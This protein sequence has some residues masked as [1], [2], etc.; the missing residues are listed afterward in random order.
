MTI[1][2][3]ELLVKEFPEL[4]Q[5]VIVN[6]L[7][8]CNN[9]ADLATERLNDVRDRLT[10]KR[11]R[12]ERTMEPL[13]VVPLK[14]PKTNYKDANDTCITSHISFI[15][16]DMFIRK[17]ININAAAEEAHSQQTSNDGTLNKENTMA[18][19]WKGEPIKN[20][21]GRTYYSA[22]V[23]DGELLEIGDTVYMRTG[24]VEPWFAQI[25]SF[26]DDKDADFMF[27][28][29]FFSHGRETIL[30][31]LAGER[32]L[33][34]L[35]N[36]ADNDLYSVMGK[37]NVI[38]LNGDV[39]EPR[40]FSKKDWWFYRL[41]YD[42]ENAVFED[43]DRHEDP[44]G[45]SSCAARHAQKECEI[46]KWGDDYVSYQGT[47]Y[48]IFD[49]VYTLIGET[50]MP[51]VI[52][53]II[54]ID[55][56]RQTI[57]VCI[58]H[59]TDQSSELDHYALIDDTTT[60]PYKDAR[61]LDK[62]EEIQ[63]LSLENLEGKCWVVNKSSIQNIASY[64]KD[65]ADNFYTNDEITIC[66]TCQKER[67]NIQEQQ[68]K[69]RQSTAKLQALD[70][71]AGCGG[72][73]VGMDD[74]GIIHTTHSIE[75]NPDAAKTFKRNF[76]TSTVH[77]QC[78]N[79]LLTRAIASYGHG[80]E[81]P[82]LDDF[83][84][85]PLRAMPAPGEIDFIYCG[86]PC[87]GFSVLN[88]HK[89]PGEIKNTLVCSAMSYVDFYRPSYFLL[90]NVR[91]LVSYKLGK[92]QINNGVLKF[93][94][95]CLTSMG[96]QVRFAVLQAAQYGVAQTRRRLFVWGAKIG[97]QLPE[98]PQPTTCSD[99][100]NNTI[101]KFADGTEVD[102]VTRTGKRAPLSMLTVGDTISDLP[103]FDYESPNARSNIPIFN[104]T[105]G[106]PGKSRQNYTNDPKTDFQTWLRGDAQKLY[107]HVTR[108]FNEINVERIC[109]IK[110]E[111]NADHNTL[112]KELVPWCLNRDNPVA[113]RHKYWPG[114]YG[115]LDYEQQFQT[116]VTELNP[117]SKQGTVIHPNQHR[118]LTV[119]EAARSQ[120]FP[121]WFVFKATN[122]KTSN[123]KVQAMY[124]QIGNAVPVPLAAILGNCLK[125]AMF[126]DWIE[127]H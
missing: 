117:L 47:E 56:A 17:M 57:Q 126:E 114:L 84:G 105:S 121:D 53:Q 86:P 71:F 16:K 41:W 82:P 20:E 51:Y 68:K 59:R 49:F 45:C 62:T 102:H 21:N 2:N 50:N 61:L 116:A 27:H 118:V 28:A 3:T 96:Y 89:K 81:L 97:K 69:F 40:T 120:G 58:M 72:L 4:E 92:D 107:N 25:M 36:C 44:D 11:G 19:E 48:H 110:M 122:M 87:Q 46:P 119:R 43:A 73:T 85:K 6:V 123:Q 24:D 12:E 112:P 80:M 39:E 54:G 127:E 38:R 67:L 98:F 60:Q 22:A 52:A 91:G 30:D 100:A 88:Q 124:M 55:N 70:I 9:D 101:I 99:Y 64:K 34:L 113:K 35:D 94:I 83:H 26:F 18:V 15:A 7:N 1:N 66:E 125:D 14:K 111:P 37:A 108:A 42:P 23:V 109:G 8:D 79:V 115:R 32:E 90:E 63:E 29:R 103:A 10:V 13:D 104:A 95:R 31:E 93:I 106:P 76:R 75:F 5:C 65:A 78:A 77:N 33:F 74:T